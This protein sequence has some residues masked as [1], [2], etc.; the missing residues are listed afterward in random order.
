ML[1]VDMATTTTGSPQVMCSWDTII[2]STSDEPQSMVQIDFRAPYARIDVCN[3]LCALAERV[4]VALPSPDQW[5]T[6]GERVGVRASAH[7][8][9]DC[10]RF[11]HSMANKYDI[12]MPADATAVNVLN[13]VRVYVRALEC[14][15]S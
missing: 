15:L 6:P 9:T 10:T 1:C 2:D 11:L 7:I 8:T 4:G 12:D 14:G 5:D 3:E 13:K